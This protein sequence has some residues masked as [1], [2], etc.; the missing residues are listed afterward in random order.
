MNPENYRGIS[1]INSISKIFT[2][3]LTSR[4]Q[5]WAEDKRVI[6]ESQ[7]GSEKHILRLTIFFPS[8]QSFKNTFADRG[9]DSIAYLSILS[10]RLTVYHIPNYGIHFKERE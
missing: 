4:L 1:L 6:D 7:A 8:K 3:I 5:K 10:V 9:V 2:G